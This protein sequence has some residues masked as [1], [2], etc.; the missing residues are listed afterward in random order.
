MQ[1]NFI[2]CMLVAGSFAMALHYQSILKQFLFCPVPL[3]YGIKSGTGKTSSSIIGQAPTGAYPSRFVSKASFEKYS[4][5]SCSSYFPLA[6]DNPKSRSAIS[7]LTIALFNGAAEAT[8]K[9]D[10]R[11]PNSMAV[12][13]ANFTLEKEKYVKAPLL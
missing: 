2:P 10:K 7:D 13:I 1:H 5:M 4:E 12:I 11:S 3:A 8:I 9:H 6:V